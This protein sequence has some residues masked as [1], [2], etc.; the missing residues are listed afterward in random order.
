MLI[1]LQRTQ[2]DSAI[3]HSRSAMC[4]H[5]ELFIRN[6]SAVIAIRLHD[7]GKPT[8]EYVVSLQHTLCNAKIQELTQAGKNE[9]FQNEWGGF[10]GECICS[11]S[12]K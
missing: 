9:S 7:T 11:E 2:A 12:E 3:H 8:Q 4:M 6:T 10:V 5:S 1:F